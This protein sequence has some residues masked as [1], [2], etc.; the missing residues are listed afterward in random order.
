MRKAQ[1]AKTQTIPRDWWDFSTCP[2]EELSFCVTH[3]YFRQIAM[4][5][6]ERFGKNWTPK[7]FEIVFDGY[8][9]DGKRVE[10][11]GTTDGQL[12]NPF[13][14]NLAVTKSFARAATNCTGFPDRPYLALT[15]EERKAWV[16]A[17][18][19]DKIASRSTDHG[20]GRFF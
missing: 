2:K 7:T 12:T 6:R 15:V 5:H 1:K 10:F 8:F 9:K 20:A 18:G 14:I 16:K 17:F 13:E 3:E 11:K 19:L 4:A